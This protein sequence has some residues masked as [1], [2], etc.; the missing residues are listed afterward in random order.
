[1]VGRVCA[2]PCLTEE[3][4]PCQ[5]TAATPTKSISIYL[6]FLFFPLSVGRQQSKQAGREYIKASERMNEQRPPKVC[7]EQKRTDERTNEERRRQ[8]RREE[9]EKGGEGEERS[10]GRP[11]C[12]GRGPAAVVVWS[13]VLG[14]GVPSPL[15]LAGREGDGGSTQRIKRGGGGDD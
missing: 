7:R 13:G 9:T 12:W 10:A 2:V 5:S 15:C 14:V 3:S 4:A 1:M 11:R 8:R 6:A